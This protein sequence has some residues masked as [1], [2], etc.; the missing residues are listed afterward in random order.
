MYFRYF[1]NSPFSLKLA[2]VEHTTKGLSTKKCPP[3]PF[4]FGRGTKCLLKLKNQV[5]VS[6]A[7]G[8]RSLWQ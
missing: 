7:P 5:Q 2:A 3:S 4:S 1:K 6:V 8:S